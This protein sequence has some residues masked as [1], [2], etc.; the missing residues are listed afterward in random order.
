MQFKTLIISLIITAF[1]FS[2]YT[3]AQVIEEGDIF[4]DIYAGGPNLGFN[5][6]KTALNLSNKFDNLTFDSNP[7]FGA[8]VGYFFSENIAISLDVN[9]NTSETKFTSNDS[10]QH[11]YTLTIPKLRILARLEYH[12]NTSSNLDIYFPLGIGYK[13]SNYLIN[14]TNTSFIITDL[15]LPTFLPLSAK[16]GIGAKYYFTKN[17]G[18]GGEFGFGGGPLFEGGLTV[19]I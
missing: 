15:K 12:L 1:S 8:R 2:N 4:V 3:N 10:L 17:I 11:E 5:A 9:Y 7:V 13:H 16:I 6:V 19:K 14:T 18:I